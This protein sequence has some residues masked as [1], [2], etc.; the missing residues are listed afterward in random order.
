MIRNNSVC[1]VLAASGDQALAP[2]TTN[3]LSLNPGQLGLF[4]ARTNQAVNPN[5]SA[6]T[7]HMYFAMGVDSTGNGNTDDI[8]KGAG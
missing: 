4:D 6:L 1:E 3:L 5:G 7:P 8:L 2:A